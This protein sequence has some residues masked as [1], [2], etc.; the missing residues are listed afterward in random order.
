MDGSGLPKM[1]LQPSEGEAEW[2]SLPG[3]DYLPSQRS[4]RE[5]VVKEAMEF[6]DMISNS[7][8]FPVLFYRNWELSAPLRLLHVIINAL[9]YHSIQY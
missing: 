9:G 6:L 4:C 2:P 3:E 8:H 1:Q 5:E 7:F